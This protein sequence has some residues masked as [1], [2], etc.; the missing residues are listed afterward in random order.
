MPISTERHVA[1]P[2]NVSSRVSLSPETNP[3]VAVAHATPHKLRADGKALCCVHW[4]GKGVLVAVAVG[5]L[6]IA[7]VGVTVGVLV[8]APVGVFVGVKVGVLVGVWFP[9]TM[10]IVV[11]P[12][13]PRLS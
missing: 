12:V 11:E 9:T 2:S 3:C 8:G 1:P 5:V 6:V 4:P 10:V 7:R 13:A